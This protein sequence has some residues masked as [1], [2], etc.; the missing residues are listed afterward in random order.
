MIGFHARALTVLAFGVIT[1]SVAHAAWTDADPNP[2]A[3]V[4]VT[5]RLEGLPAEVVFGAPFELVVVRQ[6]PLGE[7]L[8]PFEDTRLAPLAVELMDVRRRDLDGKYEERLVF[9]ARAYELQPLQLSFEGAGPM[10]VNSAL[11]DPDDRTLEIPLDPIGPP[12]RPWWQAAIFGVFVVAAAAIAYRRRATQRRAL[13]VAAT[14]ERVPDPADLALEAL[15]ALGDA[16]DGPGR[17]RA[18]AA[19]ADIVRTLLART[20]RASALE[21][22]SGELIAEFQ[23]DPRIDGGMLAQLSSLLGAADLAKFACWTPDVAAWDGALKAA[24]SIA[25]D[26]RGGMRVR[27]QEAAR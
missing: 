25:E 15:R 23:N 7:S 8:P 11:A 10:A 19:A 17:S 5:T 26:M 13:P 20:L 14:N 1:F 2:G 4:G 27:V 12:W 18:V 16:S 9:R 21:R 22:T 3:D 24:R 6:G